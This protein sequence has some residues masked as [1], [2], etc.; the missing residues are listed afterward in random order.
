MLRIY[1]NKANKT[2]YL[3]NSP[4]IFLLIILSSVFSLQSV[5][6]NYIVNSNIDAVA[7]NLVTGETATPGQI[8][9]RSAIQAA[10]AQ[11]GAH[12]I[13]FSG[14][15]V[16]PINLSLGQIT[17]GNAANG[18]NITI[19]GPGMNLL[20]VNQTTEN[21]IFSTGTGAVTILLQDI[22]FNYAGPAVTPYSGGGGAII[23][24]GAGAASTFINCRFTN[25]QRQIGNGGAISQSSSL[26]SHNLTIT[27]CIFTNNR[28]GGAGGAVSFNSQGGTATI[29]GC[30]FD[31]NHTGP[32]GANTGGDG[33][34]L[35]VTG[36]G[37]GGTYLVERNTFLNN[38]VENVTGHAGAVMNTNGTLTLRFNRF[39]GNTCANVAF[40][41]LANIVGQ[42]GGAT[43]HVTIADNNWWGVNTGPGTNDATALAAGA[44]MTLTKWLQLKTT[45]SPNPICNTPAGLGNTTTVTTSFLSNSAN[46]AI[47]V[48]NLPVLIGLPVTWGPTTLGS[49]SGQQGTIQAAGTATALFTS[50]GTGGTATV[51]TQVDNIPAGETSPARANITVNTLPI[52][53]NPA[54]F[55]SCVGGTATFTSTITGT[56]VPTITWYK[57]GAPIVNGPTGT[58]ATYSGATTN[59]LT[60]TNVQPGDGGNFHVDAVN[61]CGTAT[62]S[63]AALIVNAVTGG[64]VAADQ[65]ICSGGD[66][67]AFTQF[68]AST[69]SGVLTYQWQSSTTSCVAGFSDI[70]GA[71]GITFDPPSGLA[72]TT[73]YRR[74]TTSLLNAIPCTANSNCITVT[75]NAVTGGTVA[76]DE[77]ICS[78]GDPAAFT[79]T[80][81]ST[82]GGALTYQ[83]QSS[84]TSCAAGFSDI[85]GATATTYDP[86]AGLLVTTY[87]RRVTT[88]TLNA[89]PC[90]ANSNCL[91]VTVNPD[92]TVGPAS[93]SPTLCINTLL[94][95]I[96]HATTGATGI[97]NDGVSGANGL[98]VGVSATWAANTIT[99]SGTPTASGIFNYS[100]L[101]TGGCGTFSATGTITVT[102]NNTAGAA[103]ST[104]T[105]CINT[106]LTNITHTTTGATG[107]TNDG[108]PGANG[109]PA[110]VSA[111][112]A[113]NTITIS[114]TPTASG[115]F[116]YSILL[117][118][119]C[120][121]INATGTITVT[122]NKT[123][124]AAS[125]TPTL[126]IN[127]VLTNITHTTTGATGKANDGVSGAN[128]LPAG[129]SATWAANTITISG[130]PTASGI[131]NYSILLTGGCGTASATGTI[132]VNENNTITLTSAPGTNVQLVVVNNPITNITYAT[133]GAT[134]ATVSPLPAGVTGVWAGNVVTISGTPTALGIFNYTVTLTGGC[135]NIT[136]TGTITVI[137]CSITLTSAAGTNAQTVCLNTP[138]VNITYVTVG[139]TGANFSNLPAGVTG[140]WAV[141]VATITGTPT[142]T[143]NF[144]YT[145]TLTGGGCGIFSATGSITVNPIP[146]VDQPADQVVCTGSPTTTV[147]FSGSVPGTIFN[148]TNNTA[149]I[150]LAGAG[151]GNIASF[152]AT[153]ASNAPVTATITVTPVF[154]S[155]GIAYIGNYYSGNVSM[156][157][158]ATNTVINT[159]PGVSGPYGVAV[160]PAGTKIYLTNYLGA[161]ISVISKATNTVT[162]TIAVGNQ[163]VGAAVSPD[164]AKLYVT[165]LNSNN[166]S[167][168]NA[169][170]NTVTTTVA[171]GIHPFGVVV[172]PDGS[173]VYVANQGSNNV[174]VISTATNT[175]TATIAAG[176]GAAGLAISPDG[177]KLYVTNEFSNSVSVINTATNTVTATIVI[178]GTP[179]SFGITV[180][181]DGTK[182]FVANENANTVSVINGVTNTI[183]ATIAVGTQPQGMSVSADGTKVYVANASSSNV[184]VIS[185][186][187][188]T[189]ITTVPV[190]SGPW[191]FGNFIAND[192]CTGSAKTFTIT[193]NPLPT[194]TCPGNQ[195]TNNSP[196]LCSA[197]VTYSSSST[198]TPT[199]AI[200]Y[201]FTGATTASGSGNGSGSAF[202]VGVTNVTL[203]ATNSCGIATCPFTVTVIDNQPPVITT[204]AANKTSATDAG[205]C[206][207][208]FTAAQIGLPTASDNC[209]YILSWSRS[210]AAP[211]LTD[212]FPFG[213]TTITWTA[214]DPAGL[215][216]S[217][218][219]T[220][221]INLIATNTTV[222]VTPGTQQYSD[223]V[224]FVATV[225]QN[226]C[227]GA[228][229]IGGIVTFKIGT[230]VMGTAPVLADGTATLANVAL[231]EPVPFGTAPTGQMAPGT[232]TVTAIYSGADADYTVTNATTA[233]TITCEDAR[234]Y[235]TGSY[236]ASTSSPTSSNAVVTLSATIKDI[237]AVPTD[238]AYDANPG[239]IRNAKIRFVNRD[240]LVTDPG[241]YISGWL[242]VG[243]VNPADP[244]VG[245]ATYNWSKTI[246]G[247]AQ[248]FTIGIIVNNYYCRNN[249]DDDALV[250]VAKPLGELFIS[251]GGY[252]V[253]TNSAGIK[254]GTTGTK[255]NFGFNVKYNNAG[256]NLKG[257]INIIIRRMEPDNI[258]HV[259]QVKGNSMTSLIV[260]T[261]CPKTATFNGK[262]NIQDITDPLNVISLGGNQTLQVKMTDMGDPGSSDKIAIT[263][264]NPQG[265]VWFASNW[266][267]TTTIEQV[268]GGGNLKVHG[269]TPCGNNFVEPPKSVNNTITKTSNTITDTRQD[270]IPFSVNVYPNPT[271]GNINVQVISNSNEAIMVRIMDSKG[272]VMQS[273]TTYTRSGL[274]TI[275]NKYHAG[276]YFAEVTQGKNRQVVKITKTN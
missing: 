260:N 182:V 275:A 168:I 107:I 201:T 29:T 138:I 55:T 198:G 108:V 255:N 176:P 2:G 16:S 157:S 203:T 136:A 142:A 113:A 158:I 25:F 175:V 250:T 134:G 137:A 72:V 129:V 224:T 115:I 254:A 40:P 51:N 77:T 259:Y 200:T 234:A 210:D 65:T 221:N 274:L 27:N 43:I 252:L 228:G 68:V 251:G 106:G 256:T 229:P 161:A 117:T 166:V 3:K 154:S 143:G 95:N 216:A 233:L 227:P 241:Y 247:D 195:S 226:N 230:Q 243:L 140:A 131:F 92:N 261:S 48:G 37:S 206:T 109:L 85:G 62:T 141:N 184:S 14:A 272:I 263:V 173:K 50:N 172:S 110:G 22:T 225:T 149:S 187:T 167:V 4:L 91:T 235:Y 94:T 116:N 214:T 88:S 119:G 193:V 276:T 61:H 13:T 105:L 220:I 253:L 218:T 269:G 170:T 89:V 217:C 21:R 122:A 262:A 127:T 174:S 83:W 153:N 96:T 146:T 8:T 151:S 76:A 67:G 144:N 26:T 121:A 264:W 112:W 9:L 171:V 5:A 202:N 266:N 135:G 59:T 209:S 64:T 32:V 160:N 238:A 23:A 126:C 93:S 165:N 237:T 46:E 47:A 258:M 52:V 128:G 79:Q 265:G 267:G 194:I 38:Q 99:I 19:T 232:R 130:T 63:T 270:V 102:P 240:L 54:N 211:N 35:S 215:T 246:T 180:S 103:S 41:P 120:G 17:L 24:G 39:I 60:I 73:F 114:G 123:A 236:Y 169:V 231:L 58:G 244:T 90:T 75:V 271:P 66:P 192:L 125:S 183:T 10:T 74:V 155:G 111:T 186:A 87:Y 163:P 70:G 188:N 82:G 219:Q 56:P 97:A 81:A 245:T 178:A 139:A 207:K 197:I 31:N 249:S 124:G 69:G 33:G 12:I 44:V 84:T 152:T 30:T 101:L 118:G 212:P 18:N 242:N 78:G 7:V 100:I 204:C 190:G 145:V 36:G 273:L 189:V 196:G 6:Q 162:A 191:A 223:M 45:A 159:I 147:T 98:P 104:P 71:T 268:L 34:A 86:P 132:T 179:G 53:T 164:G 156:V 248:T 133:T 213:I 49:L 257:N 205:S 150:G 181:P 222:T 20:T 57:G 185:T 42:A 80:G 208:T 15:V 28:A 239:D 1:Q 199:P 148:W 177:T 11:P